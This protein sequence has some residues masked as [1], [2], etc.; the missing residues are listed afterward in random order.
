MPRDLTADYSA[1]FA[2]RVHLPKRIE[3]LRE[4]YR[5][6][7]PFPHIVIDDLF[8]PAILDP[9][10]DEMGGMSE[11]RWRTVETQAVERIRRM[12]SGVELGSA[13]AQ[14]VGLVHSASFLYLLSEITGIWQLL[15]DPYLQGAGYAAMRRGDFF[16]VHSDRNIAYDTGL[17]RRLAMIVFLNKG[18]DPKYHGQLELWNDAGTQCDVSVDPLYNRTIIF[19]VADP[20][21]HG[22]PTPI[23]CPEGRSR[24]SFIVYYHTV[25]VDGKSAITPHTSV[26]APGFYQA[27]PSRLRVLAR[28]MTPPVLVK[29]ARKLASLLK[30]A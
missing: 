20:N 8:S 27:S 30:S 1:L 26:F 9:V 10:L 23:D 6:A 25:G 5:A 11:E 28:E 15:P 21:Y 7:A 18:W 16:N 3:E 24:Q 13:G 2:N 4:T 14:L 29:A 22:V 17:T 19:E 12:R